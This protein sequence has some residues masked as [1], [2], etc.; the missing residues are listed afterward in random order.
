MLAGIEGPWAVQVVPGSHL[1]TRGFN[2]MQPGSA[3]SVVDA[4]TSRPRFG[5]VEM[6]YLRRRLLLIP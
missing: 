2:L 6:A 4:L 1:D 5:E 3:F